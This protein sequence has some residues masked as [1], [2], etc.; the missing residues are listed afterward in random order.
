V[1]G[2]SSSNAEKDAQRSDKGKAAL[3]IEMTKI[4]GI[5]FINLNIWLAEG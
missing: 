3:G 1:A 4:R 5:R 2:Y